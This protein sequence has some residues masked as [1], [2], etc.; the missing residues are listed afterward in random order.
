MSRSLVLPLTILATAL[1]APAMAADVTWSVTEG[2]A[3]PARG[4]WHITFQ[5]DRVAGHA[6]MMS[7][8]G[9][10]VTYHVQGQRRNGEMMLERGNPSDRVACAYRGKVTDGGS[11]VTGMALCG[12]SP[13]SWVAVKR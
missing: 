2:G 4:I 13:S 9:Q 11:K 3:S 10:R 1:S 8:N 6:E 5:G 7:A 12:K